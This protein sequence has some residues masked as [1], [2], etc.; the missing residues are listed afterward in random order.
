MPS[1]TNCLPDNLM[2]VHVQRGA[3]LLIIIVL[4]IFMGLNLQDKA[5]SISLDTAMY[6]EGAMILLEG[7][8]PYIDFVDINPH[9]ATYLHI[10]PVLVARLIGISPIAGF[11]LCLLLATLASCITTYR[12][13]CR[14]ET[15]T[16]NH[17]RNALIALSPALLLGLLS[18]NLE[19]GQ[20]SQLLVLAL[21]PYL[22]VRLLRARSQ[23]PANSTAVLTGFFLGL[24]ICLKPPHYIAIIAPAEL[25]LL[26]RYRNFKAL[27]APEILTIIGVGIIYGIHF[28]SLPAAATDAFFNVHMPLIIESYSAY[29]ATSN[30]MMSQALQILPKSLI[31]ISGCWF[32]LAQDKDTLHRDL[33]NMIGTLACAGICIF[34]L[35]QKGWAYHAIPVWFSALV[36]GSSVAGFI[37]FSP[38][39]KR[40]NI[41]IKRT[42]VLILVTLVT[43]CF[44]ATFNRTVLT[45]EQI[46]KI[47]AAGLI[48]QHTKPT[49]RVYIMST[50]VLASYPF[51]LQTNRRNAS[52]FPFAFFIPLLYQTAE[53]DP[54]IKHGY[55]LSDERRELEADY[56]K[57]L[58]NDIGTNKPALIFVRN[59]RTCVACPGGL[60]LPDYVE[61]HSKALSNF[62]EYTFLQTSG[63]Y[64]VYIRADI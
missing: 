30:E 21:L 16:I 50:D 56:L 62:S 25:F 15:A 29:G 54:S 18:T 35:Q 4:M 37:L 43:A 19:L 27:I 46:L 64:L 12:L 17:G 44:Y 60:R 20:R 33:A 58:N 57:Q 39:F 63:Q 47:E 7:G 14:D 49:D 32:F 22:I 42:P 36:L 40:P 13:L 26:Y 59:L 5:L 1:A 34:L 28:L 38:S 48:E 31:V 10:P 3:L 8:T 41:F 53:Y 6:L 9:L 51:L 52:R 61:H 45:G 55:R 23:P 24:I 2:T 11:L